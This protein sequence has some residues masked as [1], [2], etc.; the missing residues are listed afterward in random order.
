MGGTATAAY[1]RLAAVRAVVSILSPIALLSPGRRF[2]FLSPAS[3]FLGRALVAA[4]GM[5]VH[6][7]NPGSPSLRW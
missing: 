7:G 3:R 1:W 6:V 2:L 5:A 4:A